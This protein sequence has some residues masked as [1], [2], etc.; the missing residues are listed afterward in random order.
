MSMIKEDTTVGG[1]NIAKDLQ[2]SAVVKEGP[3]T[4]VNAAPIAGPSNR[5]ASPALLPPAPF[6]LIIPL[7]PSSVPG[8]VPIA[9]PPT[10]TLTRILE[11]VPDVD[12][13]F[14]YPLINT[15]LPNLGDDPIHTAEYILGAILEME[16]KFP[17]VKG[18]TKGKR[19]SAVDEVS[20]SR[21]EGKENI[22]NDDERKEKRA[23]VDWAS[24]DRPFMGTEKYRDLAMVFCFLVEKCSS[25]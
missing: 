24:T 22:S 6:D 7:D 1:S 5:P 21:E 8:P 19:K 9:D 14:L 2:R 15:H 13:V 18:C 3:M 11:V 20:G 17:K 25:S 12:P 16:G 4:I 23:K 10:Q